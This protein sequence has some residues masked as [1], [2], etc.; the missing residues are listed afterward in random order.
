MYLHKTVNI[1]FQR[2]FVSLNCAHS[3]EFI[4]IGFY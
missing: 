3:K 2:E 1:T 4:Q